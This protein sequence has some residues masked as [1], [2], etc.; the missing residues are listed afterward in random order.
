[1]LCAVIFSVTA[2]AFGVDILNNVIV[3]GMKY[4]V[5]E[6]VVC[7]IVCPRLSL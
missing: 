4:C 3:E 1:M 5:C 6:G 7:L 2:S